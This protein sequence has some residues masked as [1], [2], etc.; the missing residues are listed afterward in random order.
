MQS[1]VRKPGS[2]GRSAY[3]KNHTPQN[4]ATTVGGWWEEVE[5]GAGEGGCCDLLARPHDGQGI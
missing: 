1:D 5:V 2:P 4:K 3:R